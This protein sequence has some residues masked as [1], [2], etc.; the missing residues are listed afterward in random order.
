MLF[1][2]SWNFFF[3]FFYLLC[4]LGY[5]QLLFHEVCINSAGYQ[6]VTE[7]GRAFF[8]FLFFWFPH[9]PVARAS[10]FLTI[11]SN[12]CCCS[13][14]CALRASSVA[15]EA[16]RV[17]SAASQAV[18][19]LYREHLSLSLIFNNTIEAAAAATNYAPRYSID[20][21]DPL[22]RLFFFSSSSHPWRFDFDCEYMKT[23]THCK[24]ETSKKQLPDTAATTKEF[25]CAPLSNLSKD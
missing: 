13:P 14:L 7:W 23:L 6:S 19:N 18:N 12:C 2:H 15:A 17:H 21:H 3:F 5:I 20:V 25:Y 24:M 4:V 11:S 9:A 1:Q 8:F 10:M 22:L 16:I